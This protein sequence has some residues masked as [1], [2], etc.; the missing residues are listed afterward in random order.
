MTKS[1]LCKHFDETSWRNSGKNHYVWVASTSQAVCYKV[2]PSRSREAFER[3]V[4]NL[5]KAPTVTDRYGVYRCL[6]KDHQY[7]MSHLIRE[8]HSYAERDGPDGEIGGAI[9]RSLQQACGIQS[10]FRRELISHRSRNQRLRHCRKKLE[11]YLIDAL[12]AGSEE[13][14][15]LSERILD[16]FD[17]LWVFAKF[18]DVDPTNN[19]AERDLRKL[20]LWRKKSYGTRSERGKQFVERIT[21]VAGTVKRSGKNAMSFIQKVVSAFYSELDAP[22]ICAASGY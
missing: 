7:C 16:H 4:G 12:A 18:K 20:V 3:F 19:L 8:F 9:E 6:Q 15:G 13:L 1:A 17:N 5:G 10:R 21:S 11:Y 22:H 14:A 2:D